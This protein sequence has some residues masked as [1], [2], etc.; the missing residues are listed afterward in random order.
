M[1]IE[2]GEFWIEH[3]EYYYICNYDKKYIVFVPEEQAV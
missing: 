2:Q 3:I 1:A